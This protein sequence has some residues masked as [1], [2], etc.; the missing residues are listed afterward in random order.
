MLI[1]IKAIHGT[2]FVGPISLSLMKKLHFISIIVGFKNQFLNNKESEVI[3]VVWSQKKGMG[4][5]FGSPVPIG[6]PI[7]VFLE[8]EGFFCCCWEAPTAASPPKRP[9][10]RLLFSPSLIFLLLI[11]V[12][13]NGSKL[14]GNP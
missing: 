9:S 6:S 3:Q 11:S 7:P 13:K 14:F 2:Q 10:P 1:S 4:N 12:K 5:L 8:L